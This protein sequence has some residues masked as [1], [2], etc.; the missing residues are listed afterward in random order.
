MKEMDTVLVPESLIKD[1]S[2]SITSR[3]VA[4]YVMSRGNGAAIL[5]EEV[6]KALGVTDYK[7]RIAWRELA[8]SG[9]VTRTRVA[10]NAC[11]PDA[12]KFFYSFNAD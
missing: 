8:A 2:I 6:I 7:L 5:N 3:L 12:G 4:M 11:K 10:P 1:T 9:W